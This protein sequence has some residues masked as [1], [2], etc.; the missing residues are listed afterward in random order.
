ML[1]TVLDHKADT[2]MGSFGWCVR[3]ESGDEECVPPP[4][5]YVVTV[6]WAV[7]LISGFAPDP[8]LVGLR[9]PW[10]PLI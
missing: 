2:W 3:A 7:G 6:N 10:A 5:L 9:S 1:T 8:H 4:M